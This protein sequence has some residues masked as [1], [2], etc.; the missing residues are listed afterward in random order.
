MTAELLS[1][2]IEQGYI[3]ARGEPR[4]IDSA[5]IEKLVRALAKST[6]EGHH[7]S[8]ATL[9]QHEPLHIPLPDES[10]PVSWKLFTDGKMIASAQA[11]DG[12]IALPPDLAIGSYDLAVDTANGLRRQILILIAPDM[13][14]QTPLFHDGGRTWLL[15][16]QL[17]A[18][19][20]TRN[21][22]HGDFSDLAQLLKIA[23]RVGAAGV[24]VNPLH[25]LAP[26]QASAYSPSSRVFLNPLYIDVEAIPEF[27]GVD[28]CGLTEEIALLRSSDVI[29]YA[30]VYV[31]KRKAL[32][33]AYAV[34]NDQA[35]P[36]R[37]EAF[38][39]FRERLGKPL[40][41]FSLFETLHNRIATEWQQWPPE[42][43]QP[44]DA[45]ATG[46]PTGLGDVGFAAFLQWV[47]D[48]QLRACAQ[49]AH[50]MALPIGLYL[51]VAVGVDRGG[52]DVW[53]AQD[54]LCQSLS[55]GAP[56]DIYNPRGQNWGLAS[57]H[58][59]GLIDSDFSLFREMLRSVMQYAGAIRIDHA[60]GLNRLYLIPV[61]S[62]AADGA[63]VRFPFA[64]MLGVIAQESA[65]NRCLVIGED[66]G[67][68][69]AGVCEALNSWGVWSYKVAL[70][71]REHGAF[72]RPE[73]YPDKA[74]VTFN[75]HDLPTFAGWSSMHDLGVK[76]ALGIDAGETQAERQ[77]AH[78]ALRATLTEQGLASDL[79]FLDVLRYLARTRSQLLV[80]SLEDILGLNDQPNIPTTT[81]EHPNWR[82]RLPVDI[83]AVAKHEM[84]HSVARVMA[85][86]GRGCAKASS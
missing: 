25:A 5:T 57:L 15:S 6:N 66:L 72:R 48:Q 26:G 39:L 34:F 16:V 68:V 67:T 63:Y 9:R 44:R 21:W 83:N 27:P 7:D 64:A 40:E 13:A 82:Q 78:D 53:A 47:A 20:S 3:D 51:D 29:D 86:E 4:S 84:L 35:S 73:H 37:R 24:G 36:A 79:S 31:T 10:G 54:K 18:V 76:A 56:P 41:R 12:T 11:G 32:L 8:V 33:A 22:G 14:Y 81:T 60:L 74:L 69:P 23:A 55:I 30:S 62:A 58:P 45:L 59:Q 71:E 19:R 75:T 77:N 80:V 17:Y 46:Q 43:Q 70:F 49:M 1:W 50:D 2:G 28:A 52:A 65:N 38:A 85:A 61:G 42:W